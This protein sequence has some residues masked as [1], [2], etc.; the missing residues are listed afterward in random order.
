MCVGWIPDPTLV[1][2]V[3]HSLTLSSVAC[4]SVQHE[5]RPVTGCYRLFRFS[6]PKYALRIFCLRFIRAGG[7]FGEIPR[8]RPGW[9]DIQLLSSPAGWGNTDLHRIHSSAQAPMCCTRNHN[10]Q[11]HGHTNAYI[12][13]S[14]ARIWGGVKQGQPEHKKAK[15]DV[16]P[17]SL[18]PLGPAFRR[19]SGV[20]VSV[21]LVS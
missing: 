6:C 1:R 7:A 17:A 10:R 21:S 13:R 18:W 4:N 3:V 8:S 9:F 19:E 16:P 15:N 5:N 2:T 11:A 14:P 20:G 12:T